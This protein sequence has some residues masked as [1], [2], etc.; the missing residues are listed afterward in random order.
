[1]EVPW[2]CYM[3]SERVIL[4]CPVMLVEWSVTPLI[5]FTF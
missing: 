4:K 3:T 5:F 2:L 1:M